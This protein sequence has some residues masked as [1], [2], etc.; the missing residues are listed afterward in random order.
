MAAPTREN[1]RADP[2]L[3]TMRSQPWIDAAVETPA[4][5]PEVVG[6]LLPEFEGCAL[7]LAPDRDAPPLALAPLP[8]TALLLPVGCDCTEN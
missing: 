1:N 2:I 3:M 4:L 5:F 8:L 6:A 7:P